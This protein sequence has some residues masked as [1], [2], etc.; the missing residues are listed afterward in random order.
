MRVL[1]KK[2]IFFGK[3]LDVLFEFKKKKNRLAQKAPSLGKLL[4]ESI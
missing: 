1:K 2:I 3:L 4:S